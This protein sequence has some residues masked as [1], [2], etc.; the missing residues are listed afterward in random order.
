M[1]II[2]LAGRIEGSGVTRYII[3]LNNA[4]KLEGHDA[5]IIYFNNNLKSANDMQNI[6]DLITMSYGQELID[7]I[8]AADILFINSPI[9]V[10]AD[11][12]HRDN[13]FKL[14]RE[15]SGPIKVM[16]CNDHNIMGMR[17]YYGLDFVNDPE[18]LLK[19][20]DKFV[21]FSPYNT[22][23]KKIQK[24][25]PEIV[26]KYVHMALPYTFS[27][28]EIVPFE[29][30]YR[31]VTY[32]GRFAPFK[33]PMRL[34]RNRKSF[35]DNNYQLEMRGIART[36]ASACVDGFLY[37]IDENGTRLGPAK[38]T[39]DLTGGKK[40]IEKLFP[41]ED[42]D[43][44]HY[45]D[46]DLNKVYMFGRYEREAGM[47]ATSYSL[48]GC[49]FYFHKDPLAL[50]DTMEYAIAEIIDAGTIPLL[51]KETIDA[52]RVY[53][54]NGMRTKDSMANYPCGIGIAKDG[55]NIDDA[56]AQMNAL[57]EDKEAYDKYRRDC[58]EFYKEFY[59]PRKIAK[60]L[61]ADVT[62]N[63]NSAALEEFD[64]EK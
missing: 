42:P 53:D 44:I 2:Q 48:F 14:I 59:N 61:I 25:Y 40:V 43:L 11:Q 15:T 49:D 26:D 63:D 56:I 6:P 32:L 46:R 34:T 41:G 54:E 36:I 52:F 23:F 22:I 8:N 64:Y 19:H 55:S 16:F 7:T 3:E 10:K 38:G 60:R 58:L 47:K 39:L 45:N 21:T 33:D 30:K 27:D 4:L 35:V 20:I 17:S 29:D 9:S 12:V 37:D 62:S 1:K 5:K 57:A 51:D 50:G 28:R 31:R 24:V 13:F 18:I